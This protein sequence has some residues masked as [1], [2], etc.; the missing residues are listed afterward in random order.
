MGSQVK[1]PVNGIGAGVLL[2]VIASHQ[3]ASATY[4]QVGAGDMGPSWP[5]G[6]PLNSPKQLSALPVL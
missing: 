3:E 6:G 2:R 4:H 1:Y 5:L